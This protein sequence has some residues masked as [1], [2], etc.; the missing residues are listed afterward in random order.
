MHSD[1]VA[2]F[3]A[4]A[5]ELKDSIR[6]RSRSQQPERVGY[7][8]NVHVA[9]HIGAEH[10]SGPMEFFR[11]DHHG[12]RTSRFIDEGTGVVGLDEQAYPNLIKLAVSIQRTGSFRNAVSVRF[13]EDTL[14]RWCLETLRNPETTAAI[15]CIIRR[16]EEK[17]RPIEV[18]VP[19]YA[20]HTQSEFSLGQVQFKSITREMVDTWQ[21][22]VREKAGTN[23][24]IAYALETQRKLIQ[25][26]AAAVS[27]VEAEPVRAYEIASELADTAASLLR[28]FAPA[29]FDPQELSFCVPLGSHEREGHHYLIV[30]NGQIATEIR[31]ITPRGT[32]PWVIDEAALRELQAAGLAQISTLFAKDP[33]TQLEQTVFDALLLYSK[34]ALV[35]HTSEKLLYMFTAL[36]SS[37]LRNSSEPIT[38]NVGERVAFLAGGDADSRVRIAKLATEAYAVRSSFVHHGKRQEDYDLTEFMM[39]AWNAMH[40]LV[41]NASRF[42]TKEELLDIIE[43]HKYR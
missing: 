15:D 41:G 21:N 34:A 7:K 33:K 20:L 10:L 22:G 13:I 31:G 3:N 43:R 35:P 37:L 16:A 17:V 42:R 30:E 4:K 24:A 25:G 1:A 2:A 14:F 23:P 27:T 28:F 12:N 26:F 9:F 8:P 5:N 39:C 19:I 32:N 29:N 6:V 18:W 36:E 40:A 11:C 38:Q